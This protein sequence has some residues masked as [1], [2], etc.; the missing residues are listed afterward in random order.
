MKSKHCEWCDTGFETEISYQKYCSVE[1]RESATR[2]KIAER[3][4]IK[5]RNNKKHKN[6]KCK[7][8]HSPLSIYNDGELCSNCL[9]NPQEV[10]KTLKE[11]KGLADG[12]NNS[13][14]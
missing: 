13:D 2:E 6:R 3:Y 12:Q 14:S 8:C 7:S 10:K 4:N 5:R 1:C 9:V 11:I